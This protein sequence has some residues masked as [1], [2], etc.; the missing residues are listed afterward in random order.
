[1]NLDTVTDTHSWYKILPHNG[2]N[3]IRA[4][5]RLHRSRKRVCES[6]SSRC[7]SQKLFAD[8]TLEFGKTCEDLSWNHRTST[9]HRCETNGIADRAIRR[10]KRREL[11]LCRCNLAWMKKWWSASM[12]CYCFLRNV[13]DLLADGKIFTKGDSENHS[14]AQ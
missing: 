11:L 10:I 9:P 8:N 4:K 2:L 14:N 5:R 3:P 12:E 13:Q 1:M 6:S 7:K